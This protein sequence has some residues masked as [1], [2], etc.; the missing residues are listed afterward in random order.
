MQ[1]FGRVFL[2]AL[3]LTGVAA[4]AGAQPG[5]G[6]ANQP[7]SRAL[8]PT[9]YSPLA[10]P[11]AVA[12]IWSNPASIGLEGEGGLIFTKPAS[13]DKF[14]TIY[15]DD[16]GFA[17]SSGGGA[18]L[19]YEILNGVDKASRGTW[20][21]GGQVM[22]GVN[23]GFTYHWTS[24][25]DRQ[26]SWDAG[27]LVRPTRWLSLAFVG[28]DLIGGRIGSYEPDPTYRMGASLRPFG[29]RLTLS[30]D[31][32]LW[33]A[34]GDN[35]GFLDPT[36][37]ADMTVAHGISLRGGYDMEQKVAFGGLALTMDVLQIGSWHGF[38]SDAPNGAPEDGGV[39]WVK[40][41][42]Q[43]HKSVF[44]RVLPRRIVKMELDGP[45]VEENAGF[46]FFIGHNR[47]LLETVKRIDQL[48][49]DDRVSGLYL[50]IDNLRAS[51]SQMTELREALLRFRRAGKQV[52]VFAYDYGMGSYYL[53][54]AADK[55]YIYPEGDVWI[56]GMGMNTPFF[57]GTLD[58][59]H[60]EAQ[61]V[62]EGK[63]KSASETFTRE[64]M[65]D[66]A[67][68]ADDA[69]LATWWDE[70]VNGVAE[71]RQ[72]DRETV[73]S[74]VDMAVHQGQSLVDDGIV[75]AVVYPD[76]IDKTLKKDLAG[77]K[78][79]LVTSESAFF[80]TPMAKESWKSMRTP[81]VAVVYAVGTITTG[82]STSNFL[83]GS[84][85]MG[86]ESIARAIRT[87][88]QDPTVDAIVLRVDSP[89]GSAL[90][91]DII[92][93]EIRR[94]TDRSIKGVR[95]V[96]VIVSMSS[97]AASGG[98]YISALAD[99]IVA[100]R[101]SITGSIGVLSGH[102]AIEA[103]LD[104]LFGITFDKVSRG[105]N[106]ALN[107]NVKLNDEQLDIL[108][109]GASHT[110]D[111]FKGIVAD[112]RGLDA[113]RVQEIAQGRVW[114]GKDALEIGLVD[115]NGGLWDAIQ[116]AKERAGA[117]DAEVM[118]L[119]LYPG[120]N[121]VPLTSEV[122]AL[123]LMKDTAGVREVLKAKEQIARFDSDEPL[124]LLPMDEEGLTIQ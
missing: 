60:M 121:G 16:F 76:E 11:D 39:S 110:Y 67:R 6:F 104:S 111:T 93:R 9:P 40:I 17:V 37:T 71:G 91:S 86:S 63:Y 44:N 31:G 57:K 96:P 33:K 20:G 48:R 28:N 12:G 29:N 112:G 68:E 98:Y 107:Q 5:F 73:T 8:M 14:S 77:D 113:E 38:Q 120:I 53:A 59:L 92:A 74:W 82:E 87:A 105:R 46:G 18:A 80:A 101:A 23:L 26:N 89:G 54:T 45:I 103:G 1:T 19:A 27:L 42:S 58:K 116:V 81:T 66:A 75:D 100:P 34:P 61:F 52:A 85:T 118:E 78:H 72:V 84:R 122:G 36:F 114:S 90:A 50:N 88:R 124:M 13:L 65:S 3:L 15:S 69:L 43:S 4:A 22:P 115:I 119:K 49:K 32:T 70:W 24:N 55:V 56:A 123:L 30:V 99:T 41:S 10:A 2:I 35:Y 64:E 109:R 94:T 25:L 21:L 62:H 97:V 106:V 79:V 102:F 51:F 47:T 108:Q 83:S 95:H 7:V 117:N